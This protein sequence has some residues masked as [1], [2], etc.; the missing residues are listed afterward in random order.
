MHTGG[1]IDI[2]HLVGFLTGT[3]LYGMLLVLVARGPARPDWFAVAT[4]ILGMAWNLGALAASAVRDT[5]V[6]GAA[7]W[8]NVAAY[9]ALGLLASVVVHS[10]ARVS[11]RGRRAIAVVVYGGSLL[12]A[13]LHLRAAAAGA[14]LPSPDGLAW[15][16]GALV[17]AVAF[18]TV[19]LRS[20][21]PH[22][23]AL[24]LATLAVV[25]VSV[26]HLG[27][28]HGAQESW[29]IELVGHHASMLLAFALLYQ[30]FRFAF[31]DLFLKQA[32]ALLALVA[33]AG[34]GYATVSPWLHSTGGETPPE[35]I[36]MLLALW[37]GTA[38]VFPV[39]RRAIT[40]F[41]D[42]AV[43][44]RQGSA[45][46]AS[47]LTS[48]LQRRDGVEAVLDYT[49]RALAPALTASRV[50][51]HEATVG[52]AGPD[53]VRQ[54]AVETTE[55]P[56]YR[57]IVGPLE[58]GRRLLSDDLAMLERAAYETARR[59][60]ALRLTSERYERMLR[61]REMQSL[62]SEAEL[63]ALRA[64]INP[65]FLFNALTT[66]TYLIDQAP[67]RARAAM[68]R[69]TTLLRSALKPDGG[70]TTLGRERELVESYLRIE[71]ERFEERLVYALDIPDELGDVQLPS[72]VVQ[73]LVENAVKHGISG[74]A[75]GG[76]VTVSARL[77]SD[78]RL[79]VRNTGAPLGARPAAPGF[80]LGLQNV[81]RRLRHL[82][83]S[84]AGLSLARAE[85]GATVAEI[86]I[87][88]NLLV[89]SKA[90]VLSSRS[91]G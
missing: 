48:G 38:L 23:G 53:G 28:L 2:L 69:L 61:E 13:L 57:L 39:V 78:L 50:S 15:L 17:I 59:I 76:T 71:Q 70:F 81:E 41:V 12:A 19:A 80:G 43:L 16:T 91:E 10:T 60:D 73:P 27:R 45:H 65:H 31:A 77:G 20:P 22:R 64:Q 52:A 86:R 74:A 89:E 5:S 35:A 6:A 37:V 33:I 40:R 42:H 21:H 14:A 63:L 87:P 82:Y 88:R 24:W 51:W 25:A 67:H 18:L 36:G 29:P 66:I 46:F 34:G 8:L 56:R 4:A 85:D 32:L 11:A 47:E 79:S 72:L 62:A 75:A 3:V 54:V 7:P 26:L 44:G 84:Q 90:L 83:G 30:D 9:G 58:G 55:E 49:C 1:S 68:L